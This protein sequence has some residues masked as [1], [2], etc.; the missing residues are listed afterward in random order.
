MKKILIYWLLSLSLF[1][2]VIT[3]VGTGSNSDKSIAYDKAIKNA[4]IEALNTAGVFI[5]SEL[6]ITEHSSL[7]SFKSEF[8]EKLFQKS[9]G[10]VSFIKV[11]HQD[12]TQEGQIYICEL[13]ATFDVQQSDIENSLEIIK[14]LDKLA[15]SKASKSE[16]KGL[17]EEIQKLK[18]KISNQKLTNII[19]KNSTQIINQIKIN[20]S[21]TIENN[22]DELLYFIVGGLLLI[23]MLMLFLNNRKKD[24]IVKHIIENPTIEDI[25]D[26]QK[27][28]DE[29]FLSLEKNIFYDGDKLSLRFRIDSEVKQFYIY[30][31]NLDTNNNILL[32]ELF[33]GA[34]IVQANQEYIFPDYADGFCIVAPF[35][36]DIIKVF[37]SKTKLTIPNISKNTRSLKFDILDDRGLQNPTDDTISQYD[38]VDYFNRFAVLQNSICYKTKK[39]K[40]TI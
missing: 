37:A 4:K 20:N 33:S 6:E 5:K 39:D 31:Y 21:T 17:L 14:R 16:I 30:A 36:D 28:D 10:L 38:I 27:K 7:N 15:Q 24:I 26:T 25:A 3:S 12:F 11:L 8:K 19:N 23:I 13:K 2:N 35:G 18:S 22:T 40:E 29:I 9:E 32:L 34:N 1:A